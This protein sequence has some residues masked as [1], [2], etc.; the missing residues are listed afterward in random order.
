[1]QGRSRVEASSGIWLHGESGGTARRFTPESQCAA[2]M[3]R[4]QIV[5]RQRADWV[6]DG[7]RRL[8]SQREDALQNTQPGVVPRLILGLA[9]AGLT[10]AANE[11]LDVPSHRTGRADLRHPAVD[12]LHRKADLRKKPSHWWHE[13][14]GLAVLGCVRARP[15]PTSSCRP[16]SLVRGGDGTTAKRPVHKAFQD[17]RS[18]R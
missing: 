2:F 15:A 3:G 9:A 5:T 4:G 14:E 13:G 17:W 1:V 16:G 8:L 11:D 12:W 6:R 7:R 18:R 10:L